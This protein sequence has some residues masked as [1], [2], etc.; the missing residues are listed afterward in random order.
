MYIKKLNMDLTLTSVVFESCPPPY[1]SL[2]TR[3]LTLTSVVFEFN[4]NFSFKSGNTNLT[5]TS[6]VFEL[7]GA[8]A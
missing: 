3:H 2:N 7:V 6:V 8:P 1:Q 5:L 4:L